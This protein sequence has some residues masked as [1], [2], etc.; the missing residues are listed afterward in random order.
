M[1]DL[2]KLLRTTSQGVMQ[3]LIIMWVQW[4]DETRQSQAD[5]PPTAKPRTNATTTITK[6]TSKPSRRRVVPRGHR[7][8]PASLD[9]ASQPLTVTP[10]NRLWLAITPSDVVAS[11]LSTY[12][13]H[14]PEEAIKGSLHLHPRYIKEFST[15]FTL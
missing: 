7:L 12:P 10:R 1:Q 9:E 5:R 6:R 4:R 13:K 8:R 2:G 15:H 3:A 14:Q 11:K